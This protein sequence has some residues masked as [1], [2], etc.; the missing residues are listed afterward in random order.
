MAK[1]EMIL[2]LLID[3][4][5]NL[6]EGE[7]PGWWRPWQ[8]VIF[9]SF[10][11]FSLV[12]LQ[13]C[14]QAVG[15]T[16][17]AGLLAVIYIVLGYRV[18]VGMPS[19]RQGSR[20]LLE[21]ILRW[22]MCLEG[23]LGLKRRIDNALEVVWTNGGALMALST[24]EAAA[25]GV[26]GYTCALL[27]LDEGHETIDDLF[28]TYS[29]L[30]AIAM[31]EGYGAI[32]IL[33]VGG[34][35]DSVI[36]KKKDAGY[37]VEFWDDCAVLQ[38]DPSWGPYFEQQKR[39]LTADGYDK[40]YR[41]LPVSAG[42][43]YLFPQL[44]DAVNFKGT[45][46]SHDVVGIDVGK[47]ADATVLARA[48]VSG[49]AIIVE[50]F[51]AWRGTTY[52]TQAREIAEYLGPRALGDGINTPTLLGRDTA[53]EVNGPGEGLADCLELEYPFSDLTRVFTTDTPP[54]RYKTSWI[55]ELQR[56]AQGGL[57]VVKPARERNDLKSLRYEITEEGRYIWPHSDTLSSLWVLQ[58][59]AWHAVGV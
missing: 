55:K 45:W 37:H 11:R 47:R 18:V 58:A 12:I 2:R 4:T 9:E 33:G 56:K 6:P 49:D 22:M 57:L 42:E 15:K 10:L 20:I 34:T 59:C 19:L 40:M 27:I 54:G 7:Q 48:T 3:A 26:Q 51:H 50:D 1:V 52:P 5:Q 38:M 36:E 53:I 41:C 14:R 31:K 13:G 17:L 35:A 44:L 21:R 25:K 24:N 29:P 8:P 30:V 32:V 46:R 16:F 39:E 28:A 23:V 43:R